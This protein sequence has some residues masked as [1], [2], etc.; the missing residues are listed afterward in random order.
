MTPGVG[1]RLVTG[2]SHRPRST[3]PNQA[4]PAFLAVT[5]RYKRT[6]CLWLE[7]FRSADSGRLMSARLAREGKCR[8]AGSVVPQRR[9]L[10]GAAQA[11]RFRDPFRRLTEALAVGRAATWAGRVWLCRPGGSSWTVP[12][13]G[14]RYSSADCLAALLP[15]DPPQARASWYAVS[16]MRARSAARTAS[17]CGA[18]GT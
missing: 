9:R 8:S 16:P 11:G 13:H 15:M 4:R 14:N 6:N 12:G 17:S 7:P 1:D 2:R 18:R 5:H 10:L 3:R